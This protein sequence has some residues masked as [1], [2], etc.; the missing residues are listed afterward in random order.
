MTSLDSTPSAALVPAVFLDRDGVLI[1]DLGQPCLEEHLKPI[2]G[3]A[4]AVRRLNRLGYLV[5][6]VDHL[7]GAPHG[8]AGREQVQAFNAL[9][10]RRLARD[11][12]VIGAVC[13][14]P[15]DPEGP[16]ARWGNADRTPDPDILLRAVAEHRIDPARSFMIGA[17]PTVAETARRAGLSGFRFEGGDLDAFVRELIG[18]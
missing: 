12:A 18:A 7:H 2:P 17:Q 6:A 16:D 3:A 8:P 11:G 14:R 5:V 9:L 4:A 13:A 15:V 10:V 1:D